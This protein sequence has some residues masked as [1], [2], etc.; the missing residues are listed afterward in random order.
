MSLRSE[1]VRVFNELIANGKKISD[2][3]AL[4]SVVQNGDLFEV[5]RGGVNYQG[6]G[7]QLPSGGGAGTWGGITGTLSDQTDLQAALDLKEA[8]R[9]TYRRETANTTLALSDQSGGIEMNVVG[10]NDVQVPLFAT[11]AFQPGAFI[12]II[13]YGAGLTSITKENPSIVIHTSGGNLD[14][15]GQYAPMFLRNIAADEWYLWNGTPGAGGGTVTSVTGTAGRISVGGTATDPVIDIDSAYD[16]AITAEIDAKVID[17]IADSDTTHAPSRNAVFDALALKAP[18]ASPTFTGVPAAPT[19][20]VGTNTTQLATTAYVQANALVLKSSLIYPTFN[21]YAAAPIDTSGNGQANLEFINLGNLIGNTEDRN[22]VPGGFYRAIGSILMSRNTVWNAASSRWE[23]SFSTANGYGA[24]WV[25][26]GGEGV[27]IMAAPVGTHPY[28]METGGMNFSFR[29]AGLRSVTGYTTGFVNQSMAPLAIVFES[30]ASGLGQY[31]ENTGAQPLFHA[32]SEETKGSG[33]ALGEFYRAEQHGSSY[34][35]Y[36]FRSSNGT[37]GSPS[38][39]SSNKVVGAVYS[40]PYGGAYRRTAEMQF[41]TRGTV[42]GSAVGQS[43]L[44]RTSPDTDANLADRFEITYDGLLTSKT[45]P[46]RF[47]HSSVSAIPSYS[48]FATFTVAPSTSTIGQIQQISTSTGGLRVIGLG[49]T[50]TASTAIAA[51]ITGILG[52]TAPTAPAVVIQALKHNGTTSATDLASGESAFTVR[53]NATN[54]FNL[55]A[56]GY[57]VLARVNTG[58][59][60]ITTATTNTSTTAPYI[61]SAT[62]NMRF[63]GRPGS[64]GSVF[65][66]VTHTDTFDATHLPTTTS[67][68]SIGGFTMN[69]T[70]GSDTLTGVLYTPTINTTGTYTNGKFIGYDYNP[71]LTS[72]TGLTHVAALFR[73]GMVGIGVA[74]SPTAYLHIGAGVAAASGAPLKLTTGTN[75]TAAEAG[76]FEYDNTLYFTQSDATRRNFVLA[77]N[78]TKTTAGA[79]YTNDGYITVRIGGTDVR[80]M[81]T[82]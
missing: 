44:F 74:A 60:T 49:T 15:P 30:A 13:Q 82:A 3:P 81:T 58:R 67:F 4:P 2:L 76:A 9:R 68:I 45:A 66:F 38:N 69:P 48:A 29:G 6:T 26:I 19:A 25:E 22:L 20:A 52:A 12:P 27:N 46:A 50:S 37:Y 23:Y 78:A 34:G 11:V 56:E 7:S 18:L 28:S 24:A 40:T 59:V 73:T 5:V 62:N 21:A 43:M 17:S 39:S 42:T 55:F 64:S 75:L 33:G 65:S 14:S 63:F 32:L 1:V 8:L 35:A 70:S 72:I 71:T 53:N 80:L 79:P 16:T 77:E 61:D 10:A 51:M 36:S 57:G 47:E 31:L 54:I 41:I